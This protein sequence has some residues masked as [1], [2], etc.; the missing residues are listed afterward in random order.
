M[1]RTSEGII[2]IAVFFDALTGEVNEKY[3]KN[4]NK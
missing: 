3:T 4:P 1:V 2:N